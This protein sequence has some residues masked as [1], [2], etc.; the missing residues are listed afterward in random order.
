MR[1]RPYVHDNLFGILKVF[2]K[3][4]VVKLCYSDFF[5]V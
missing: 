3:E 1:Q 4:L 5:V 2:I